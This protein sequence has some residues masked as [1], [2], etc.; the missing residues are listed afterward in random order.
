MASDKRVQV[1][2]LCD[3]CKRHNYITLKNKINDRDRLEMKKYCR[4]CRQHTGHTE[5]R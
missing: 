3:D 1:T 2:L 4:H 5:K